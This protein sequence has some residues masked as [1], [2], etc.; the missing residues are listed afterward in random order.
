MYLGIEGAF[1]GPG[2]KT[3]IPCKVLGKFSIRIVPNMEPDKV[4]DLVV[5]YLEKLWK[6]RGSPNKFRYFL[7]ELF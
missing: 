4:D 7:F 3:V 5:A 1:Y 6:E 2:A